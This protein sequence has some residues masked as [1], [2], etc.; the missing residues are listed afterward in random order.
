MFYYDKNPFIA[1]SFSEVESVSKEVK[2][3]TNTTI[4]CVV[5]GLTA[6]ATLSWLTSSGE[7]S[8]ENF[9]SSQGKYSN[10]KQTSTL[11]VK[12]TQVNSDTAYTCR[13]TSG[14]TPTFESD[15][16]VDL[17]VYGRCHI[18][19]AVDFAHTLSILIRC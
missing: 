2:T 7:V 10:G 19:I 6:E 3:G 15:T 5:T 12:G 4:S 1:L 16:I 9:T 13:V 18:V 17:N 11:A 8:G 14:S